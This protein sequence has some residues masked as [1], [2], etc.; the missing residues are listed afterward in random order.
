MKLLQR[1]NLYHSVSIII[2]LIVSGVLGYNLIRGIIN[3]EFNEKLFAD[4][5]QFLF[6]WHTYENIQEVF[7]LNIGD[8]VDIQSIPTKQFIAPTLRDTVMWDDYE[9]K[10]LP[11]RQLLFSDTLNG[12]N[13]AITITKSLLPTEDMVRGISEFILLLTIGLILSLTYVNWQI[14]RK[15]WKPF[16][17]TLSKL[18]HF[19]IGKPSRIEFKKTHVKEFDELN[20]I[21]DKMLAQS[22]REYTLLKEFTE[23]ASHEIQ[24]PLAI[25]KSKLENMLQDPRLARDQLEEISKI[26]ESVNR[27]S[28]LKTGL[29][30]LAKIDNNQFKAWEKIALVPF[31][32]NKLVDFEELIA[33]KNI[34]VQEEFLANPTL[35][36]HSSLAFVLIQNLIGNAIKHNVPGGRLFIQITDRDLVFENTG[37]ALADPPETYFQRFKK[38]S[39]SNDSSGLGL[40]LIKKICDLHDMP[41]TY[42]EREGVHRIVIRLS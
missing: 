41:I 14:S 30:L 28:K 31:I 19:K 24:T 37:P 4:R 13:Y 42:T 6:E 20:D 21:I 26:D 23:N 15:L 33:H 27:L 1:T 5:D 10:E 29:A 39:I 17:D 38:G 18:D 3:K 9:K 34:K 8:R 35:T 36:M 25:I 22:Q 40:A 11:F 32:E 16:F 12:E 2:I 7:Y